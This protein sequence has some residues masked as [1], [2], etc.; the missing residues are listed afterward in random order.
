MD[1]EN[2]VP[3]SPDYKS[4]YRWAPSNLLEETSSFTT[5]ARIVAYRKSEDCHKSRILGREHDKF[6]RVVP[7]RVG[8]P[9]CCDESSDPKGP[10]CFIYFTVLKKLSLRLP[11]TGF[12]RAV[13]TEINV[14]PAQLHPNSWGF[15]RFFSILCHHFGHS[16]SVDVFLHF[17]EAKIPDK[18][19]WVSFN[20]VAE[21]FLLTLFQQSYKGFKGKFF[22]VRCNRRDPTL[23]D[24]FPLYWAEKP[25]L[26]K[27][28]CLEDLPPRE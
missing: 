8:E 27:P 25:K 26:K 6:V 15:V 3:P 7:C 1:Q 9:V 21:R 23:L 20:G 11:F 17:F 16:S 18:K 12:E 22:K 5:H 14:A 13:L 10:F 2:L 19:L 4:L 24:E 28:K